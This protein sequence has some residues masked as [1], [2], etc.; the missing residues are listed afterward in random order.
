[1]YTENS[2]TREIRAG[3]IADTK[4]FLTGLESGASIDQLRGV[5]QRIREKEL[6]LLKEGGAM[7]DPKIWRILHNR[8]E[9]HRGQEIIDNM[10]PMPPIQS[11]PGSSL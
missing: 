8:L 9:L 11:D 3:I 6:L 7:V 4:A 2:A 10:T 5:L 1:M